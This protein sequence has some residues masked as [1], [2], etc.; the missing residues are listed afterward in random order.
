MIEKVWLLLIAGE[1]LATAAYKTKS[2]SSYQL[3]CQAAAHNVMYKYTEYLSGL[4][5]VT[6]NRS[7]IIYLRYYKTRETQIFQSINFLVI[8]ISEFQ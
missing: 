7:G 6:D 4:M 5:P 1:L 8:P 3:T 2:I